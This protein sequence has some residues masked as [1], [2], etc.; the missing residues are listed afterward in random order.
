MTVT[1]TYDGV[2][3]RVRVS[4]TGLNAA[5][6]ATVERSTDG[7][8]WTTVR[9]GSQVPVSAGTMSLSVDDY[10]FVDGVPNTY[11]VRGVATAAAA[12]VGVGTSASG[13]NT[14]VA[15]GLPA[16]AAADD[17]VLI[18]ASIRNSSAG[19]PNTPA[20]W[21]VVQAL[22]NEVIFG[23]VYDGVWTMPTV[24]FTGGVS[25]A[26][27]LVESAA[28]RRT[29]MPA[30]TAATQV[31]TSGQNIAFPALNPPQ[32]GCVLVLAVWKQDDW[33]SVSAP[34]GWTL[35]DQVSSIAGA[36]AGEA[37]WYQTQTTAVNIATGSVSVTG[38]AAAVSRAI[39][40]ALPHAAYINEQTAAITPSLGAVWLKDIG[41]P[42]LNRPVTVLMGDDN[43]ITRKSRDGVFDIVG[44]SD[45]IAVTDLRGSKQ[46]I[47]QLQTSTVDEATAID[48][49]LST[50]DPMF[51]HC[52]A[53]CQVP[54]GYVR[55]GDTTQTWHPLRPEQSLFTLPVQE[56][57]APGPDVV[58][59]L[60]TWQTVLN[61]Y[62]TWSAV[63]AA[64]ATWADLLNLIGSPSEVI[65]P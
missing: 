45:P 9:A 24:S 21:T 10:E 53:G 28:F 35:M 46:W 52:P 23:R 44:R 36:D 62:A 1:L 25:G 60:G 27:T 40:A 42:F 48:F 15:A 39:L 34:A 41:R 56:V 2:L 33:T 59:T 61:T 20:S 7:L 30:V 37:W 8:R 51:I 31:N 4:A 14:S 3:S 32:D 55:I 65:V 22:A 6:Y 54:G 38:G 58:G 64:N 11:R 43:P 13:N 18:H 19:V 16:G 50:G 47:L 29:G 5:N 49:A 26:D 63:I 57:T 12:F 17:L